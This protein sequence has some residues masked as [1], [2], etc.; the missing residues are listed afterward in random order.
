MFPDHANHVSAFGSSHLPF[1]ILSPFLK[2][3]LFREIWSVIMNKDKF[4]GLETQGSS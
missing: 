3:R 4:D 2:A 1:V